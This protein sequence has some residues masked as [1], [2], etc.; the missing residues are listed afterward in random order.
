MSDKLTA[1]LESFPNLANRALVMLLLDPNNVDKIEA[2]IK[3]NAVT[4]VR[5]ARLGE[6]AGLETGGIWNEMPRKCS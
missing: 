2:W 5:F 6:A 1:A 4:D 3:K